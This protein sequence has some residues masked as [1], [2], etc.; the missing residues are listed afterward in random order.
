MHNWTWIL[1]PHKP[2]MNV[3]GCKW[4]FHIKHH[5]N[6]IIEHYKACFVV[7]AFINNKILIMIALSVL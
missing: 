6:V 1:L 5:I 3:I 2:H 4:I 7:K